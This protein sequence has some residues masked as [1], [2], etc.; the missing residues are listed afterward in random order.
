MTCKCGAAAEWL[1][2]YCQNCWEALSD[3]EWWANIATIH[4]AQQAAR[5]TKDNSK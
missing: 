1:D 5:E 2:K 4:A 3:G